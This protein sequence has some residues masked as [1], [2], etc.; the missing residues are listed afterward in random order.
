LLD[1]MRSAD[2]N[3]EGNPG[4]RAVQQAVNARYLDDLSFAD[5][6][7]KATLGLG[8]KGSFDQLLERLELYLNAPPGQLERLNRGLGYNNLLF[9]AAELLLLQSHPEQLP[10]LLLEEPEAHLHPQHQTLF[11]Q[12]LEDKASEPPTGN[13]RQQVQV[14]LSTHS[15][16]LAAGV[17]L[18]AMI[19]MVGHKVFPLAKGQTR[20]GSTTT[21]S[22]DGFLTPP[23]PISSSRGG[24]SSSK[25]T[26]RTS[27]SQPS[28]ARSDARWVSMASPSSRSDIAVSFATAASCS[29]PM[30]ASCQYAWR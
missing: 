24:S 23:R 9:M 15:P 20:L 21:T 6:P 27:F 14:L 5:D 2:G 18:E 16:T 7:L 17:N 29:V 25:A 4:V 3:V 12:V 1:T 19:L 22:F 11:M 10:L 26:P 13:P 8:A 28:V 30:A